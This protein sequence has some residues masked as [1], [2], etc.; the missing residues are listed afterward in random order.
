L[1][2][3]AQTQALDRERPDAAEAVAVA[4][5]V[6][7]WLERPALVLG[8]LPPEGRDLDLVVRRPEREM[9]AAALSA[10]GF[11]RRGRRLS[12]RRRWIEQW[13]RFS[14]SSAFSVDLNP[15]E[16]WGLP[17]SELEALFEEAQPARGLVNVVH[18]APHHVVLLVARRL[19]RFGGTLDPKRRRRLNRA[20]SADPDAFGKA[21]ERA[22]LWGLERAI[23]MLKDAYLLD[24]PAPSRGRVRAFARL[25]ASAGGRWWI[26]TAARRV[27]SKLPRRARVVSISG[28]DGAG[29]STQSKAL[30]QT[31]R[32]LGVDVAIEWMPL[33]HAPRHRIIRLLRGT[34]NGLLAAAGR[35][36]RRSATTSSSP[37]RGAGSPAKSLRQ[38]SELVTHAWAT[39]VALH[40]AFQHRMAVMRHAGSGKV[41]IFDRYSLDA[42]AQLRY[43]YG[44]RHEFRFQKW[45]VRRISPRPVRS[46]LLDVPPEVVHARKDDMQYTLAELR[47]QAGLLAQEAARSGI[48]KLEGTRPLE[49]LSEQIAREVWSSAG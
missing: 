12:P 27:R 37:R 24:A 41:L 25:L 5:V 20:L 43:F 29:K 31:L 1:T 8:T 40:Q 46:Y 28:L 38:R 15:A 21:L 11:V 17:N 3:T 36:R 34:V 42:S 32:G 33:G 2:Q 22:P 18:P 26:D 16:R 13:A 9:A 7:S 14:G 10:N 45:L 47:E 49:D 35:L 48:P 19:A 44:S 30:E 23:E 4:Q 6:G 39:V